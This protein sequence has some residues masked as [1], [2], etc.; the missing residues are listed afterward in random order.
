MLQSINPVIGR[1][2]QNHVPELA[3][4]PIYKGTLCFHLLQYMQLN[5]I[6]SG[7]SQ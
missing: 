5:T 7:L 3:V 1:L 2:I 6:N 4:F